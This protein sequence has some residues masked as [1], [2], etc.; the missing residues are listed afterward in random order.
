M[1]HFEAPEDA[2]PYAAIESCEWE[3]EK[4]TA[5]FPAGPLKSKGKKLRSK[6]DYEF[7]VWRKGCPPGEDNPRVE[8]WEKNVSLRSCQ[9]YLEYLARPEVIAEL[10]ADFAATQSGDL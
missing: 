1:D 3:F 5:H 8:S 10:G 2:V 6:K 7:E 9:P 4:V